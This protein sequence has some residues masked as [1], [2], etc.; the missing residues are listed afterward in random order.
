MIKLVFSC[1][2]Q[3]ILTKFF[4]VTIFTDEMEE[5]KVLELFSGI[6]GMHRA[7]QLAASYLPRI[8]LKVV[9]SYQ[10]TFGGKMS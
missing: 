6:G 2:K 4:K 7:T 1:I 3:Q 8:K 10:L 5:I 9:P